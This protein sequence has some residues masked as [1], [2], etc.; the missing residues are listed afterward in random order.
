[1]LSWIV[2]SKELGA[3]EYNASG[4]HSFI[5]RSADG[6]FKTK[7]CGVWVPPVKVFE[8]FAYR[9]NGT[10]LSSENCSKCVVKPWGVKHYFSR[11]DLDVT[12]V[13]F[14]PD[15]YPSVISVI[16]L[17]N[18]TAREKKVRIDLEAAVNMRY[19]QENVHERKYQA[20]FN[21]LRK[22]VV[23]ES[24]VGCC[25]FGAGII[26]K[27]VDVASSLCRK[28]KN[29][30]P[31]SPQCCFI[32]SEYTVSFELGA[33]EEIKV[34]FVYCG[35]DK[36]RDMLVEVYDKCMQNWDRLLASKV[37]RSVKRYHDHDINTPWDRLDKA[38]IWAQYSLFGLVN[39]SDLGLGIF[40]GYPWFLEFW[41]RD[42]FWSLLGLVDMGEFESARKIFV[43]MAKFQKK[44]MPC[45]VHP[46]GRTEYHG[47]DVDPLFLI[48]LEDYEKKSG[49]LTLRKELNGV[50]KKVL[51]NLEVMDYVVVHEPS[52]TWMDSIERRGSAVEVQAMW[53]EAL[54]TIEPKLSMK[55]N[56]RLN[57]SFWN[58]N[59]K[60][61]YDSFSNMPDPE[62]TANGLVPVF[63]GLTSDTKA[64]SVLKIAEKELKSLYGI[65]TRSKM[66]RN[67]SPSGYHTGSCWG[68]TTG[69]GAA[70]FLRYGMIR[71]GLSCLDDFAYDCEKFQPGALSE[72]VDA[73]T[74][75]LLG[76]TD[77]AWSSSLFIYA[78]DDFLFGIRPDMLKKVIVI[79]PKFS[80]YW[81]HMY[82][83]GKIAGN[84]VFDMKIERTSKG[85]EV[86]INFVQEPKGLACELI[87]PGWIKRI[88]HE[89]KKVL[90]RKIKFAFKKENVVAGF[91]EYIPV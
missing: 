2:D 65:R 17:K 51:K 18:K 41:G 69:W 9:I 31:G 38:Y 70:A 36:S 55:M 46:D 66:S 4:L 28:Y 22:C 19:K 16:Y 45:I 25:M 35:S 39:K 78:V 12:E 72:V 14:A 15:D 54:K 62:V 11:D 40:A 50:I 74:G 26:E 63:F 33:H 67:Y 29:H 81:G 23:V 76:A 7:W 64:E 43:T 6:G 44:R 32:P 77:Q 59:K 52:E 13:V 30:N 75:K 60:T 68:L 57:T 89:G 8:Y 90:G 10:W 21:E 79:E 82:R 5:N 61:Y 88:Q 27:N 71:E 73:E 47:A 91:S 53:S 20:E 84:N 1:M 85:V 58:S 80:D 3:K 49:D 56:K 42:V 86:R 34:P 83:C 87:L 48:A 37:K 24:S